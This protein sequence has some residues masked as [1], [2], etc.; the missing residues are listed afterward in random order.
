MKEVNP[1][2]LAHLGG[3]VSPDGKHVMLEIEASTG[4]KMSV[5][6]HGEE[7]SKTI[8]FMIGLAQKTAAK[9]AP[10]FPEELPVLPIPVAGLGLAPGRSLTEA[11]LAMK[12]GVLTLSFAVE[13]SDLDGMCTNLRSMTAK[14]PAQ[15][16]S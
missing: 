6:L 2:R 16:P 10:D 8:E 5:T 3:A 7:L 4:D 11:I 12:L 14:T 1:P 9:T 13:L 15:K